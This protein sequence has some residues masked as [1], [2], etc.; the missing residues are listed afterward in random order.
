MVAALSLFQYLGASVLAGTVG[1]LYHC[2]GLGTALDAVGGFA[3][4]VRA[5]DVAMLRQI[6]EWI[7]ASATAI[8]QVLR[9][10]MQNLMRR[11]IDH[12]TWEQTEASLQGVLNAIVGSSEVNPIDLLNVQRLLEVLMPDLLPD[13]ARPPAASPVNQWMTT[14]EQTA[15]RA[16]HGLIADWLGQSEKIPLVEMRQSPGSAVFPGGAQESS[17]WSKARQAMTSGDGYQRALAKVAEDFYGRHKDWH[18]QLGVRGDIQSIVEAADPGMLSAFRS[19]LAAQDIPL[20]TLSELTAA[21]KEAMVL[22]IGLKQHQEGEAPESESPI[23]FD[24]RDTDDE[25]P[26]TEANSRC[27]DLIQAIAVEARKRALSEGVPALEQGLT[28]LTGVHRKYRTLFQQPP[29]D[30]FTLYDAFNLITA[31]PRLNARQFRLVS[32]AQSIAR[33]WQQNG[34]PP[35]LWITQDDRALLEVALRALVDVQIQQ[36]PG[37]I[38]Y[39][40]YQVPVNHGIADGRDVVQRLLE[41]NEGSL[42]RPIRQILDRVT[43]LKDSLADLLEALITAPR[44]ILDTYTRPTT[45]AAFAVAIL[46]MSSLVSALFHLSGLYSSLLLA[47]TISVSLHGWHR[48]E[49]SGHADTAKAALLILA[50]MVLDGARYCNEVVRRAGAILPLGRLGQGHVLA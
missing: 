29:A 12:E 19:A 39:H 41:K 28:A 1:V 30:L 10:P 23:F 5:G 4:D 32:Q 17:G 46:L 44:T 37:N 9:S 2:R 34:L 47:G 6:H 33:A 22:G 49:A 7:Q 48:L 20:Y 43:M 21:H 40:P 50:Q 31:Y 26:A 18:G 25:I 16:L 36:D 15:L 38:T 24:A 45:V 27:A 8:K 42:Q 3:Q 35:D 14:E 13:A 11:M